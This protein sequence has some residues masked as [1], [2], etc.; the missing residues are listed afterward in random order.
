MVDHQT[1]DSGAAG[2]LPFV[3]WVELIV[4]GS[5]PQE[6][7]AKTTVGIAD[8]REHLHV[9]G[10]ALYASH[11]VWEV[12]HKRLLPMLAR[13][14]FDLQVAAT[15]AT[16]GD[17]N[18]VQVRVDDLKSIVEHLCPQMVPGYIPAMHRELCAWIA[19]L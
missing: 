9:Q 3:G 11:R 14:P 6:P 8:L 16:D 4:Y 13:P 15:Y 1:S 5:S 19:S 7:K 18:Q 2:R 17:I 12:L 10:Y